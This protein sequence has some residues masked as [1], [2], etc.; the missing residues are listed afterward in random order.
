MLLNLFYLNIK[1]EWS[2]GFLPVVCSN[3]ILVQDC[4]KGKRREGTP[5]QKWTFQLPL[6]GGI[7]K[8]KIQ[9][10]SQVCKLHLTFVKGKL[11]YHTFTVVVWMGNRSY[12]LSGCGLSIP[13]TL[14]IRSPSYST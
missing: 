14:Y 8:C 11:G 6:K 2:L 7:S 9:F 10:H 4:N 5:E 3:L 1:I 12:I 13:P